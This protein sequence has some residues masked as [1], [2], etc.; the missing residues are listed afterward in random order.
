MPKITEAELNEIRYVSMADFCKRI[1]AIPDMESKRLFATRYL[2]SYG[3]DGAPTDYSF[4]E[5]MHIARIKIGD[6]SHKLKEQYED[7]ESIDKSKYWYEEDKGIVDPYTIN[8]RTDLGCEA[9][10]GNLPHYL[11]YYAEEEVDRRDNINEN[12]IGYQSSFKQNCQNIT[13]RL[14]DFD[15]EYADLYDLDINANARNALD[16]K[17]R[18]EAKAGSREA[19]NKAY[20]ATKPGFWSKAF[21]TSSLEYQNLDKMW[22]A[23]INPNHAMYGDTVGLD[24]AVNEYLHHKFPGWREG[25]EITQEM[26]SHLDKTE[27]A[28]VDFC[29]N[30]K[31]SIAEEEEMLDDFETVIFSARDRNPNFAYDDYQE[32][33][34]LDDEEESIDEEEPAKNEESK[35]DEF[36]RKIRE[37]LAEADKDNALGELK[38]GE[39]MSLD[40][41]DFVQK[42]DPEEE[43]YAVDDEDPRVEEFVQKS[44]ELGESFLDTENIK[45]AK[46][47]EERIKAYEERL[48][49]EEQLRTDLEMDEE[50][51]IDVEPQR[52]KEIERQKY[53]HGDDYEINFDDD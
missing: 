14:N 34:S 20:N 21:N 19:F 15:K 43:I 2:L 37:E 4:K 40:D 49:L 16:I 24:K 30:I 18:M 22:Q 32:D 27:K 26:L 3:M 6:A 10:M 5:V 48:H 46:A 47:E 1:D 9:F 50:V 39:E 13:N 36:A 28:R 38:E 33:K 52:Q 31:K 41:E 35:E 7:D 23:F 8:R 17:V 53:L 11:R 12:E 25:E 29:L 51:D 42:E 44:D 45:K